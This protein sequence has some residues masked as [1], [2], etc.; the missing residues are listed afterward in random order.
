MMQYFKWV[1]KTKLDNF[2]YKIRGGKKGN[3][4]YK[5]SEKEPNVDYYSFCKYQNDVVVSFQK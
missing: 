4:E 3:T 5:I 1:L 2:L